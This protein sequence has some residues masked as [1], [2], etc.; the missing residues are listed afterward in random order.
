MRKEIVVKIVNQANISTE[1]LKKALFSQSRFF[2]ISTEV[3]ENINIILEENN[4]ES[5]IIILLEKNLTKKTIES[6]IKISEDTKKVNIIN[7]KESITKEERKTLIQKESITI[8]EEVKDINVLAFNILYDY[9]QENKEFLEDEAEKSKLNE[10]QYKFVMQK[11]NECSKK[12]EFLEQIDNFLLEG[13]KY[14]FKGYKEL[15]TLILLCMICELKDKSE[16]FLYVYKAISDIFKKEESEIR[17]LIVSAINSIKVKEE[18]LKINEILQKL[19]GKP[20]IKQAITLSQILK[21][22]LNVDM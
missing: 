10:E 17:Y 18:R 15:K 9:Y 16:R 13:K 20:I 6:I 7:I 2:R 12:K 21:E 22:K 11:Y 8:I 5:I 14:N 1:K 4:I 3:K 19:N